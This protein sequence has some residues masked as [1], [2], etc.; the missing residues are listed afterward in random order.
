MAAQDSA[1]AP[2][3]V[4]AAVRA[5]G[6]RPVSHS[7]G[8][9]SSS[10]G[11]SAAARPTRK[12]AGRSPG[13]RRTARSTSSTGRAAVRPGE[14]ASR[15]G[16]ETII[17]AVSTGAA[18]SAVRR[19]TGSGRPRAATSPTAATHS[20]VTQVQATSSDGAV[21]PAR[22]LRTSPAKG[23]PENRPLSYSDPGMPSGRWKALSHSPGGRRSATAACLTARTPTS[24]HR[25]RRAAPSLPLSPMTP[26]CPFAPL[27]SAALATPRRPP[28]LLTAT[29]TSPGCRASLPARRYLP[30]DT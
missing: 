27:C 15:T 14:A 30:R 21:R 29:P 16:S 24:A 9:K 19:G 6:R 2:A 26:A 25:R 3:K 8:A 22:G 20:S 10:A 17:R 13:T 7:S 5:V 11:W 1:V 28:A 23:V 4:T 18:S 12:P